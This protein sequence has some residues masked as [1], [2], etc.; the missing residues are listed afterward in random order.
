MVWCGGICNTPKIK[1]IEAHREG[2]QKKTTRAHTGIQCSS[3]TTDKKRIF[4]RLSHRIH[5]RPLSPIPSPEFD[6]NRPPRQH[7]QHIFDAM[8]V[9]GL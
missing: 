3:R 5:K 9:G 8:A 7:R 1:G 6:G 4:T 2:K